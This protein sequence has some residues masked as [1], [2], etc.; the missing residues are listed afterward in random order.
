[1]T[2][3]I[4]SL[5]TEYFLRENEID[6]SKEYEVVSVPAR[7]LICANRFDLMA[8]WIYI[9]AREK[10]MDMTF[11]TRIYKDNIN[12]FSCGKYL[13]PGSEGKNSFQKYVD[14]FNALIDSIK[15]GGFDDSVSII[16]VGKGD[17]IFDGSHRV[18]TAAYFN[19][20]I[21]IIRFPDKT[22]VYDYNYKYFRQ[23]IMCDINMGYMARQYVNIKKNCYF[24]CIWPSAKREKL[25]VAEKILGEIGEI[26]YSQEVYLTYNGMRNFMIQ[27]YGSQ[28]WV[29][30]INNKFVGVEGK[31]DLCYAKNTPIITYIIQAGGLDEVV[32]GKTRIRD[33]FEIE[34]HSVHISDNEQETIEMA[35]LLYNPNSVNFL[36][37]AKPYEYTMVYNRLVEFKKLIEDNNFDRERFIIDSSSVLEVCGLRPAKDVD[38]MT[39]YIYENEVGSQVLNSISGIDSHEGQLKY[40]T[41][42]IKDMLYNPENH[43]FFNGFKFLSVER[44]EEMKERR[45]EPKD[46]QDVKLCNKFMVRYKQT[47]KKYR[48]E[49][50]RA[51]YE[52]QIANHNYGKGLMTYS[53]Y[54]RLKFRKKVEFLKWPGKY[55]RGVL[56]AMKT[57]VFK[58]KREMWI[59][60]QREGLKEKNITIISSNCNGGVL[61]SDLGIAFNSP[62]VNLFIQ[63]ADYIKILKD[64]PQYMSKELRFVKEVDS[65]YGSVSYPTAYLGD[66]KIYFMHY[67]S[68]EDARAAWNR[69][70]KRI[71]WDKLYI[72]FTDRSQC[73]QK[74]L[75]EFDCLPYKNKVVFTH[76]PHPEI[77]SSFYIK[78]YEREE[79]V[80]VLTD[81]EN[82][83][84]PVKRIY[85]QFDFV[86]WL[87]RDIE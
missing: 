66:V 53:E 41:L 61:S 18:S 52:Y 30:N 65:T 67:T 56:T 21:T 27:I 32:K 28:N 49:T 81:F 84:Y 48:Y 71:N 9:D 59:K 22:P 85:D 55:C 64:L 51:I 62:F 8:K 77:K 26:V 15:E 87:N 11:A 25:P 4:A 14:D 6:R 75:E 70:V 68:E 2:D 33:V 86:G 31:V 19:K 13:E 23:Y 72:L 50:I 12:A 1:M 39:D 7:S 24:V 44:L 36:N 47:P 54:R 45:K 40:H 43:F 16:P 17:R 29:G 34:N 83:R 3:E 38:F 80:P 42:S 76:V 79:K 58:Y 10:G 57:K 60:K 5:L 46:I 74:E 37:Y 35:E 78:G 63:A 82:E 20:N 73:T 69:R